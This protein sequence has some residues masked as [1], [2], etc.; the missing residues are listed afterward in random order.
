MR[1]IESIDDEISALA[2][3]LIAQ[4]VQPLETKEIEIMM[5]EAVTDLTRTKLFYRLGILRG[6]GKIKGK[7]VGSGKGVW[8]WWNERALVGKQSIPSRRL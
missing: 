8:I 2:F 6:D 7:L 4:S 5:S 1:P 3:E